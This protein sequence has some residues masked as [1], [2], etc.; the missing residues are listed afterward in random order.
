[1][2]VPQAP[3]DTTYLTNAAKLGQLARWILGSPDPAAETVRRA[4]HCTQIHPS[5]TQAALRAVYSR[6]YSTSDSDMAVITRAYKASLR[7]R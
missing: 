1:M 6:L 4:M 3:Y 2:P 7:R 5:P